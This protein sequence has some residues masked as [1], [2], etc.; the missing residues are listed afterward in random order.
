MEET[1]MTGQPA[2][3][4][5]RSNSAGGQQ[6]NVWFPLST[7]MFYM[8]V[9]LV[10]FEQVRPLGIM[11]SD[12]CFLLSLIFIPKSRWLKS[13]GSGVLLAGTLILSGALLS[14]HDTSRLPDAAGSLLRL[15]LLFGVIALLSLNH[16]KDI[17]KNLFFLAGG[18]FVNCFITLLQASFFPGIV[19]ALSINPPQPDV[20]F[21]GRYQ[22]LTEFPVT[23]GLS[24]ALAVL[25][26]IGLFSMEKSRLVRWGLAVLILVCSVA[27]L[28]S[29]SRTFFASLIPGLMFFSLLQKR[30]R[31]SVVY[32]GVALISLWGAVTYV[33]PAV[34][35]Q[36]S[37]RLENV[38]LVDYGR[39]ATA[40]QIAL[41]ISEKPI[42]GWGVDHFDGG[43]IVVVPETGEIA[44]AHN[45]FLRYW[46][47]AGVLGAIG[48][49]T[50][51]VIPTK[52]MLQVIRQNGPNK[53][54]QVV[55]LLLASYVFFF[56]VANLG[57]Y[58]YNRYLY[59]PIFMFAGFVAHAAGPI[60][61][62]KPAPQS[63]MRL[64]VQNSAVS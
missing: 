56:I 23:L 18:I 63:I 61:A 48:F 19:G 64:P 41:E 44:P 16:S 13:R 11:L 1:K 25:I 9:A 39:L 30:R 34:V 47:A 45:T 38:G 27:A 24:A 10:T 3:R 50:L 59:V 49:L 17:H 52:N 6:H 22:G 54:A 20:G 42:L 5:S 40:A 36:Y 29:G 33:A 8:G 58:L 2:K 46:Y 43:G 51:F 28:L 7:F 31:R 32:A 37:E 12:Y 4:T 55:R 57:P 21:S 14:V 35:S 62:R 26:G 53:S 60:R 15:F